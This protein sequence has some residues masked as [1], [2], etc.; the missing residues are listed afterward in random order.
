MA[1][2][3]E[4]TLDVVNRAD[5]AHD[6]EVLGSRTRT[7]PP[8]ESERLDLGLVTESLQGRCTIGDHDAAGMTMEI[9]VGR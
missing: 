9:R 1:P 8:G 6:L 2:G 4:L 3:T 5:G 7:L